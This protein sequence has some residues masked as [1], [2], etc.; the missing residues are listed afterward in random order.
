MKIV[1]V[2]SSLDN[3]KSWLNL[4]EG[5]EIA[6][7]RQTDNRGMEITVVDQN[8]KLPDNAKFDPDVKEWIECVKG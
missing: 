1:C 8:N 7:V 6:A 5:C 4:P 3:F 2:L